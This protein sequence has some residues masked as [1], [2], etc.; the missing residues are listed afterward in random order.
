MNAKETFRRILD[1]LKDERKSAFNIYTSP[2]VEQLHVNKRLRVAAIIPAHNEEDTVEKAINDLLNQTYPIGRIIVVNDCSTD[3]TGK[4]LQGLQTAIS[5]LD[6]ITNKVPALRAGAVNCGLRHLNEDEFD[7]ILTTDADCR[8]DRKLVQEAVLSFGEND[9]LGG[10]CSRAG[11]LPFH[12]KP[13]KQ[14]T[15][16]PWWKRAEARLLW[17]LQHLEYAGFDAERTATWKNV[18]IL[19]SLCSVYNLEA[20]KAVGGYTP[21]HLLEDYDLTLKL[22]EA[23]WQAM[24][25]PRMKAWTEVPKTFRA[26]IRQRLR[27]LRGGVDIIL[28]HG[29]N[30][31]TAEDAL[32]HFLFISLLFGVVLFVALTARSGWHIRL[33]WHPLPLMLAIVGYLISLYKLRYVENRDVVDTIIRVMIIPELIM[34]VVM[35]AIQGY[36]YYLAICRRPQDW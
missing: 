32:N 14:T 12:Q 33:R 19:H 18:L 31:F 3:R 22:K 24:F 4:I 27:W 15:V 21:N 25:N 11:V 6:V 23:G 9:Q 17:R 8:V 30:R 2:Y 7:L 26:L 10:V 29:I 13:L 1:S 16:V 34:A 35:S 28:G 20:V 5:K 36:A